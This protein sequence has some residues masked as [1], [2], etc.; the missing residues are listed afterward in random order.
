MF[1]LP[2]LNDVVEIVVD[3]DVIEGRK[4]PVRVYADKK[5]EAGDAA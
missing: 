2:D 5:A 1:E 4:A 3:K